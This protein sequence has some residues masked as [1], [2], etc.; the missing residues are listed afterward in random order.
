MNQDARRPHLQT[1]VTEIPVSFER[2]VTAIE[3]DG[4]GWA[5]Q[6]DCG[7]IVWF[8]VAVNR[9][10]A[11]HCSILFPAGTGAGALRESG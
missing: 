4:E 2:H 11:H 9:G 5:V 8:A 3:R 6:F 1:A 10:D 7:H